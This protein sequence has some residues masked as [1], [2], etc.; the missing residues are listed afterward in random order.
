MVVLTWLP[1]H[2]RSRGVFLAGDSAQGLFRSV[3]SN[4]T[5]QRIRVYAP[6]MRLVRFSIRRRPP[7]SFVICAEMIRF[8]GSI[9]IKV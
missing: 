1:Q 3:A 6:Y 4:V 2:Y 7:S 8:D 5:A 9:Q